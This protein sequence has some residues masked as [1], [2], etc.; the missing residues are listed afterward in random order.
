MNIPKIIAFYFPQF[1]EISENNEWWGKGFTDWELVKDAKPLYVGHNQP[2]IPIDENYYNPCEKEILK[3]QAELAKKY[4][5]DGFMFYHYWFDGRLY[6]EK[7]MEVFL[8]N[9]DIDISFC[10]TWA[11]ESWTRSWVGKPEVFLQKQLHTSDKKIWEDHFNYLLPFFRDPRAVRIEGKPVFLIY[12][13]FLINNSKEM[14]DFW[15]ELAVKN[16]LNGLYFI[17]IKN[18]DYQSTDFLSSYEAIMKF[19]PR[20]AYASKDFQEHNVSARFQF[21]RRLPHVLQL[22]LAKI[23]QKI[24]KHKIF[25][26]KK[27]WN[28]IIKNSHINEFKE[29]NLKVFES[30]FFEWDNTPRYKS[31]AKIFTGLTT[32]EKKTNL[33]QL[34]QGALKNNSPYIF[35]NAWNEWSESAY[36]EPDKKNGY[37]HL[38]IIKE[39]TDELKEEIKS[40]Y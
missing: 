5:I 15:N 13:P 32:E 40:K 27:I 4:G 8:S 16:E 7:P 28:I 31:K 19:Q 6:L 26:S 33:K 9:T 21:L 30:A 34:L 22:Y 24:S 35:F 14:I 36:L 2:R 37:K 1:H 39:V 20:E 11:N 10:V 12:Q 23:N 3:K 17:A 38:E 25:D 18:H 29:Y